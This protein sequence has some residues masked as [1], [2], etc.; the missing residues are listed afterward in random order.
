MDDLKKKIVLAIQGYCL[1]SLPK[2]IE[3]EEVTVEVLDNLSCSVRVANV[4]SIGPRYFE[5]RIKET[6]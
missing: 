1:D 2:D 5:V 6:F 3:G 4:P